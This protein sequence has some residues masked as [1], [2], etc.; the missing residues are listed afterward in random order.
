MLMVNMDCGG[1]AKINIVKTMT[2]PRERDLTAFS[3]ASINSLSKCQ[4]I[5]H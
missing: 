2:F 5:E 1:I 3:H 4:Y